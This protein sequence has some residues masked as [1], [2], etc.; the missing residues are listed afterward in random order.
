[1]TLQHGHAS[2][3]GHSPTYRTWV[4]LRE[5]CTNPKNNRFAQYGGRGIAF[6][7]RWQSF[8]N[9]LVDMGERRE[10]MSID[11]IDVNGNYEKSNCRWATKSLQNS[12]RRPYSPETR[13]K[14]SAASLGRKMSPVAVA[15]HVATRRANGSY[16]VSPETRAKM[17]AASRGKP[18]SP[19]HRAKLIAILRGKPKSPDPK[20]AL[21]AEATQS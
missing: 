10:D 8:E 21:V 4:R 2:R 13:A 11:R 17:S 14:I 19:E 9:F 16:V 3:L 5:R 15:K 12:N 20:G 7:E 18:K 6:C 1:M